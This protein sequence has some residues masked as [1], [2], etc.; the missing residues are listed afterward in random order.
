MGEFTYADDLAAEFVLSLAEQDG[1]YVLTARND[2]GLTDVMSADCYLDGKRYANRRAE[3]D[4]G[5]E[6]RIAFYPEKPATSVAVVCNGQI[7]TL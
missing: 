4:P 5:E 2:G 7:V 6:I 1:A 3:L